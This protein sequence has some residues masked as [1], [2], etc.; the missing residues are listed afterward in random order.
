[1]YSVCILDLISVIT[2]V[3]CMYSAFDSV[4]M[5][6]FCIWIHVSMMYFNQRKIVFDFVDIPYRRT[7]THTC[8]HT[9]VTSHKHAHFYTNTQIHLQNYTH[10]SNLGVFNSLTGTK[11]AVANIDKRTRPHLYVWAWLIH[12]WSMNRLYV[13]YAHAQKKSIVCHSYQVWGPGGK[14]I[15]LKIIC[16]NTFQKKRQWRT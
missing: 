7:Y 4:I 14:N 5:Y 10:A 9:P 12:E 8:A 16:K 2:Y 15:F 3:F 13:L 1:M 6:V 11:N